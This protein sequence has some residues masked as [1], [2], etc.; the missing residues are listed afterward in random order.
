MVLEKGSDPADFRAVPDDLRRVTFKAVKAVIEPYTVTVDEEILVDLRHRIRNTRW[1]SSAPG[2]AWS[3]GTDLDYLRA[4][5]DYWAD[6]FDWRARERELNAFDHFRMR[7][8]DVDIHFVHHRAVSGTGIP[9][10]LTHGWP[11]TFV[12]LLPLVPLLTDPAAHGLDGPGFDVV[13]PSLPGY[14]FSGRPARSIT[15]RDT[16]ALW[17]RL[18]SGLGYDRFGAH[19]GDFGSGVSTFLALDQPNSVIGLHLSNFELDPYLGP[20]APALT[21]D[22][23][24]LVAHEED[25]VAREGGYHLVQSTKPQTLGYALNDSPAG[26]AAWLLEKWRAWSDSDGELE[27]R[28]TRDFLLTTITLFWVTGSITD[29]MRDYYDNRNVQDLITATDRVRV[30]TAICLLDKEFAHEGVTPRS[31]AERLYNVRHWAVAPT[32]GHF[33]AAEE[34]LLL[35]RDIAAFFAGL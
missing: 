12:E 31:W 4:I 29:S 14:A 26:L 5:L 18:M 21:E 24:T 8:D 10:I 13:I 9:L 11:S 22:E 25:F 27:S 35:A 20:E 1:P 19:G 28:F 32:G 17:H 2:P 30:P 34:P 7:I 3:Q 15:M 33:A 23:R 6:A 16:A